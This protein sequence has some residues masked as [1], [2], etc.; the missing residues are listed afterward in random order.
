MAH[1][2]GPASSD[3][4][5]ECSLSHRLAEIFLVGLRMDQK[6]Q[7]DIS[8]EQFLEAKFKKAFDEVSYSF[9]IIL[10]EVRGDSKL[11]LAKQA[12]NQLQI[13]LNQFE[14]LLKEGG[15]TVG[16]CDSIKN[17]YR[18]IEHPLSELRRYFMKE[19]SEILTDKAG[20]VYVN[21]LKASFRRL[22]DIAEEMD[23]GHSSILKSTL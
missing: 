4:H 23:E 2:G 14:N 17:L 9:E 20:V 6:T 21:A 13:S 15:V 5:Q 16:S 1:A 3:V 7:V 19:P 11:V 12:V 18:E 10:G 22:M 8:Q